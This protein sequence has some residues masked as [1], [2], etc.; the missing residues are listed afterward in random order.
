MEEEKQYPKRELFLVLFVGVILLLYL[1]RLVDWQIVKGEYF[2]EK[3]NNSSAYTIKTDDIRGEILDTNGES[4]AINV[5]GY[6]III[7]KF[8]V[9]KGTENKLVK[10]LIDV[11]KLKG[12]KWIDTLPIKI[13]NDAYEFENGKDDEIS[14]LRK[15]LKLSSDADANACMQA[16]IKKY[17][18]SEYSFNDARDICSVRY[19]MT[20]TGFEAKGTTSYTFS[21]DVS[22]ETVAIV[23]E[24][25]NSSMRGVGVST[26]SV[27][28][29]VNGTVAPHVVGMI[30]KLSQEEYEKLSETYSLNDVIGKSGVEAAME[31]TLKGKGGSRIVETDSNG[32]VINIVD[33]KPASPGNTVYLTI[34]SKIQKVAN[35]SLERNIKDANKYSA[36]D[37]KAG[38]AVVLDVN[39]FSVIAASTYPSYDM[40]KYIEDNTYYNQIVTDV[41]TTPL[42]N[43]A[44]AGAFTPGSIYKPVVACAALEEKVIDKDTSIYCNGIYSY[45]QSSGFTMRCMGRHGSVSVKNALAKSCNVFFAEAGRRLG[46][47]PMDIYAKMFGL[48]IKTGVEVYESEGV[49]AGPEFSKQMGSTWYEG[50]TSQAAIGQ[51]DNMFTPL[52]L[53]TY[54]AVIAN[55]GNRYKTHVIKEIKNY[56]RSETIETKKP[57]LVEHVSVSEEN[58]NI[59]KEGMRE[60]V[61]SGTASDFANYKIPIAAKTGTAENVGSEHTTFICFAPYENPKYAIS[62]VIEHG[63]SGKWS[64]NVARDILDACFAS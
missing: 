57:E 8:A 10:D 34:D 51:S 27:R 48:G 13:T 36:S 41:E 59:V 58:L 17:N 30:G 4:L 53:A 61:R 1:I 16:L 28:K 39:D 5:G 35:E 6:K 12:E 44:F 20:N 50:N 60:V 37:C 40:N 42:M 32:S 46:I 54:T 26:S 24:K 15:T 2:R 49:L 22:T 38:A 18:C 62:V 14:E 64:K 9:E 31:S 21:N 3:A 25:S 7:N 45:Y 23:S 47:E 43:R 63:L 52:Q 29:Y 33:V 11:F 56:S 55:G 19:N